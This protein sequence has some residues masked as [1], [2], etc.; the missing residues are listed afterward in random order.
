M[1]RQFFAAGY[2][3]RYAVIKSLIISL[4]IADT[5]EGKKSTD[6]VEKLIFYTPRKICELQVHK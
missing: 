4:Q 5:G 2:Y 3:A 1:Y 6:C